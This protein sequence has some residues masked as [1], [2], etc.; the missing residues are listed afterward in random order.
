MTFPG[1][2]PVAPPPVPNCPMQ[3]MGIANNVYYWVTGVCPIT[4]SGPTGFGQSMSSVPT[5]CCADQCC[6]PVFPVTKPGTG[7][8][9]K[10]VGGFELQACARPESTPQELDDKLRE[11]IK[12]C[13]K[14]DKYL[15]K[16][17]KAGNSE[18]SDDRKD[19]IDVWKL[20]LTD[21]I[22]YLEDSHPS[23]DPIVT[24]VHNYCTIAVRAFR[25]HEANWS[26]PTL[27]PTNGKP[28]SVRDV[29][30][31]SL[32]PAD[33]VTFV[34]E[35]GVTHYP[36]SDKV[37][38]INVKDLPG[39]TSKTVYFKTFTYWKTDEGSLKA[40]QIGIQVTGPGSTPGTKNPQ[41]AK[42]KD[43]NTYGHKI[44]SD[45]DSQRFLVSSFDDLSVAIDP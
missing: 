1:P 35:A 38:E 40:A 42:F 18:I 2:P 23:A 31:A 24:R 28:S 9:V 8:M 32:L 17:S 39:S 10:K 27:K 11:I 33:N 14:L 43:R 21:L 37:W 4:P 20:Y 44:A 7:A 26:T 16:L 25:E 13:K 12:E 29:S 3:L 22:A 15:K 30:V 6:S 5:G 34:P 45:D 19:R 36:S 41:K